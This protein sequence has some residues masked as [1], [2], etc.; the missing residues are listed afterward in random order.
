MEI[1]NRAEDLKAL[2]GVPTA[3]P[4]QLQQ[5]RTVRA[6]TESE[7]AG[8]RA[9][10]SGAGAAAALQAADDSV[11]LDKVAEVRASIAAGT[12]HVPSEAVAT[13]VVDAMLA[14]RESRG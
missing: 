14:D 1:R 10:L 4:S 13:K 2:L 11:R 6:G 5:M 9:T 3:S 8:D 7:L 12:Y